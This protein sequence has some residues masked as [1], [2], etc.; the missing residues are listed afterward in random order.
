MHIASYIYR[1]SAPIGYSSPPPHW[2][3]D[4]QH[5]ADADSPDTK[6]EPASRGRSAKRTAH[7]TDRTIAPNDLR[8]AKTVF[9]AS[10]MHDAF[11]RPPGTDLTQGAQ[12]GAPCRGG[13]PRKPYLLPPENVTYRFT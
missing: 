1:F 2:V 4:A 5:K 9:A 6:I 11:L 8:R 7:R 10:T 12:I 3:G 13:T